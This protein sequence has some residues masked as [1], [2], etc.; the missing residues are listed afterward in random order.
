MQNHSS[1]ADEYDNFQPDI[2][3]A[4]SSAKALDNYLS[5]MKLSDEAVRG[6]TDYFSAAGEDTIIVFSATTSPRTQSSQLC[7]S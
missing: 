1:Y 3:V 2:E 7:G 6:L 5:L 4:N